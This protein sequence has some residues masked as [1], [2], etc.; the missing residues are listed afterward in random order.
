MIENVSEH[1]LGVH[2]TAVP[3]SILK[4]KLAL[5]YRFISS[6]LNRVHHLDVP[7]AD[8]YLP[9]HEPLQVVT[10]L[11]LLDMIHRS[12]R[13]DGSEIPSKLTLGEGGNR[14]RDYKH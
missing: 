5:S 12:E 10:A 13:G 7:P 3:A 1:G 11:L 4:L 2:R 14:K 9:L 8:F 6:C